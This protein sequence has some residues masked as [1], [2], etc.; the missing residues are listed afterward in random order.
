VTGG[1]ALLDTLHG[2]AQLIKKRLTFGE[3][4]QSAEFT[5]VRAAVQEGVERIEQALAKPLNSMGE[6]VRFDRC[7]GCF[8]KAGFSAGASLKFDMPNDGKAMGKLRGGP[9]LPRHYL[10]REAN[11]S[12]LKLKLLGGDG[13]IGITGQY[14][15]I[16][17]KGMGGIGKT[18]L[19]AAL[20]HDSEV[21]QAF[22]DGIYW[23]TIGQKPHLLDLQNQLLRQLTGFTETL[24]TEQEAKDAL[25]E[26]L[27]GR[28]ALVILDDVWT[29]DDADAF[30]VT[31][32]PT[33]LLITTR[34][35]EVLVGLGAEEHRVGVLSP[36]MRSGSWP[37]GWASKTRRIFP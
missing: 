36:Q 33:H 22:P 30:A 9:D 15:A 12:G 19:A 28:R 31:V 27:E 24:T 8:Y 37:T 6:P 25:R 14:S 20:A 34:N 26:A 17:L 29:V 1:Q 21:R 7:I 23:L 10:P 3:A 35:N 5:S 11:L 13:N 2:A 4:I 32:S 16:G 18:V